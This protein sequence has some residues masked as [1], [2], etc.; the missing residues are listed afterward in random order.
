MDPCVILRFGDPSEQL[1]AT[2]YHKFFGSLLYLCNTCLGLSYAMNFL[3][4]FMVQLK[5]VHW[6]ASKR[7]LRYLSDTISYGLTYERGKDICL[8]V[9]NDVNG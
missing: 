5:K 8:R 7:V 3:S 2:L 6:R 4:Q 1:D 9:Y